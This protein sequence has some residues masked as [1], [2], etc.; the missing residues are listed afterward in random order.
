VCVILCVIIANN[1]ESNQ[2][3]WKWDEESNNE[4]LL[5]TMTMAEKQ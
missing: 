1:I 4:K 3:M 2:P 5:M